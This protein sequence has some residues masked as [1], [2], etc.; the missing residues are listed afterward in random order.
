MPVIYAEEWD[1]HVD[2]IVDAGLSFQ[3]WCKTDPLS[4]V[5]VEVWDMSADPIA[6]VTSTV[7]DGTPRLS[8]DGFEAIARIVALTADVWYQI[9]FDVDTVSGQ[10]FVGFLKATGYDSP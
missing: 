3:R 2:E 5:D 8:S 6:N 9:R 10:H 7:V 1:Q 4:A